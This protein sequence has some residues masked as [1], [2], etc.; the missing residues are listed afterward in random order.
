MFLLKVTLEENFK[1]SLSLSPSDREK[2]TTLTIS[3]INVASKKL[4]YA[5]LNI[6]LRF[7]LHS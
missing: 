6:L 3:M 7:S 4:S 1:F 2:N 5:D